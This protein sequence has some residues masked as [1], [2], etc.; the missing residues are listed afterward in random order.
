MLSHR[1]MFPEVKELAI[2]ELQKQTMTPVKRITLYHDFDVDRNLLIADYAALIDREQPLTL[3]EGLDLGMGTTVMIAEGRE[4]ARSNRLADGSLSASKPTIHWEDLLAMVRNFFEIPPYPVEAVETPINE[5][6]TITPTDP[7]QGQAPPP[8]AK[9][10][11]NGSNT[12]ASVSDI[13]YQS[14]KLTDFLLP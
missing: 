8:P 13:N 2:R 4:I 9:D 3:A 12:G 11:V 14:V 7:K 6:T 5:D 10:T 1:W